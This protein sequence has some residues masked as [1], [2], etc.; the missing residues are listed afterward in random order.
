M[1]VVVF[2]TFAKMVDHAYQAAARLI[3]IASAKVNSVALIAK[4]NACVVP[5]IIARMVA[6][7]RR[8]S[9][10][11]HRSVS[12]EMAFREFT[13]KNVSSFGDIIHKFH[14]YLWDFFLIFT[15]A[16]GCGNNPCQNAGTCI[17]L[18]Q[19]N[20]LCICP[21]TNFGKNCE[22][23]NIGCESTVCQNGGSCALNANNVPICLCESSF[24]GTNCETCKNFFQ[25]L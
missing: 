19:N 24:T 18:N 2:K 25:L 20:Y 5:L 7:A 23:A 14:L 9:M 17:S 8:V 10:V 11:V 15:A 12:A 4:L 13:V 21:A 3:I 22:F 1:L 16:N 6:L